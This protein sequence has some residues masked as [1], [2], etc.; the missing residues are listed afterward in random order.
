M[1]YHR[2]V[3]SGRKNQTCREYQMTRLFSLKHSLD[4]L[5]SLIAIL[6]LLGVL[7]TFIIGQHFVIPTMILLLAVVF[8][9]LAR[10]A[11][12]DKMWE[13]HLLFWIFFIA[14]CHSF[15]AL[16]WA[17]TPREMLGD[18]FIFVYGG[19]LLLLGFLCWQYAKRNALFARSTL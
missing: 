11:M 7:Q 8:G 4:L 13:K 9:N 6:A 10:F 12:Q 19:D 1:A 3:S 2:I 17:K 18:A 15:F 5:A 16:F 14:A